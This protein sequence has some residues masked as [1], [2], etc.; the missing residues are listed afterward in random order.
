MRKNNIL[1]IILTYNEEKHINR[2]IE[3]FKK[4]SSD[5]IVI[6]SYSND[7]TID[8]LK[9]KKI[10]YIQNVFINQS[11]QF[12]FALKKINKK[13]KWIMRVDADEV[14]NAKDA[15][16]ILKN[17][18]NNNTNIS[19]F[20]IIKNFIFLKKKFL[21]GGV[22]PQRIVRI[23]KN[24][25]ASYVKSNWM[26][27]HLNLK[28]KVKN[29]NASITEKNLNNLNFHFLKHK[30]YSTREAIDYLLNNRKKN[31]YFNTN[32]KL[33]YQFPIFLRPIIYFFY[34]YIFKLGFLNG[35]QGL[36]FDL[37][38]G[39]IYRIAVDYKIFILKFFMTYEKKK[40]KNV[41]KK[42]YNYNI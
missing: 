34:R 30:S 3:S 33:Y 13:Y 24:G 36:F 21:F 38:Q 8:I 17:I 23:F 29:I 7:K 22:F 32:K 1:I 4:L 40:L 5:I 37:S 10:K 42:L 2:C 19:G 18:K 20:S 41:V 39:L 6:D 31:F 25:E 16:V 9:H 35:W 15:N 11:Q 26:D 27:E 12:N 14:I 28:K